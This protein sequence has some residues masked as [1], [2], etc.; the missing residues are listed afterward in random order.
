MS[1]TRAEDATASYE[2]VAE[3]L[4]NHY[5]VD[6]GRVE[7]ALSTHPTLGLLYESCASRELADAAGDRIAWRLGWE[8]K[9]PAC[10]STM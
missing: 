2:A 1:L 3:Y 10:R 4:L 8:W 6:E 5:D 9:E 7:C